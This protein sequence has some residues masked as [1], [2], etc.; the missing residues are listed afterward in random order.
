VQVKAEREQHLLA[1][2]KGYE[3]FVSDQSTIKDK[4]R[5]DL[6]RNKI[7]FEEGKHSEEKILNAKL[8][9]KSPGIP[10]KAEIIKIIKAKGIEV[11]DEIEFGFRYIQWKSNCH[12]WNQW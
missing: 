2:A 6:V 11:I 10:E 5:D 3:V 4:Y 8:V 7:E 1:K 12:Y 9:I